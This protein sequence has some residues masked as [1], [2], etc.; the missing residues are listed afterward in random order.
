MKQTL[1]N[2]II[3]LSLTDDMI[4][5]KRKIC[6][7]LVS[8]KKETYNICS[9][10]FTGEIEKPQYIHSA[11]SIYVLIKYPHF[12]PADSFVNLIIE[13]SNKECENAWLKIATDILNSDPDGINFVNN[14]DN[15]LN[16]NNKVAIV[17]E[18][19]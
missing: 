3:L 8:G 7:I 17:S 18:W 2:D 5:K 12:R 16:T 15:L 6:H 13:H 4:D 9:K 19:P 11:A 14:S 1:I 10:W